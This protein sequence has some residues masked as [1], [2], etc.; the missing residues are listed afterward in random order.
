M[1]KPGTKV[2]VRTYSAGV[3]FGTLLGG[4]GTVVHLKDSRRLWSWKGALTLNEVA[5]TGVDLKNSK[6][7]IPVEQLVLTQAIEIMP[8][9]AKSNLPCN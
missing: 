6:I 2:L 3:H 5:E 7:S 1:I 8:I 4:T 9:N